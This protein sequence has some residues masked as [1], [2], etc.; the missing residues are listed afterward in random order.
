MQIPVSLALSLVIGFSSLA[1]FPATASA[2]TPAAKP[3]TKMGVWANTDAGQVLLSAYYS[4]VSTTLP[5]GFQT[6][7]VAV[8]KAKT[9][10]SFVVQM[11]G[12]DA[13]RIA[14]YYLNG[15]TEVWAG[16]QT[17]LKTDIKTENGQ[18][19]VSSTEWNNRPPG[20]AILEIKADAA[21]IRK[22]YGVNLGKESQAPG[23][24]GTE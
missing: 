10:T 1:A 12:V 15:L 13:G 11:P 9:L 24:K 3:A 4:G 22:F 8:P 6:H 19:V 14:V 5:V 7:T 16:G 21:G 18:L 23:G 17:P 20:F 2:Q